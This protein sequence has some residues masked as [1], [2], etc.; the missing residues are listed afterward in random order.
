M[1]KVR[2]GRKS[3]RKRV[4]TQWKGCNRDIIRIMFMN[5]RV[6]TKFIHMKNSYFFTDITCVTICFFICSMFA[7]LI[8]FSLYYSSLRLVTCFYQKYNFFQQFL[9]V[10]QYLFILIVLC[11]YCLFVQQY[12]CVSRIFSFSSIFFLEVSFL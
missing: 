10:Q 5:Y 4:G 2:W 6:K 9:C 8:S 7:L 3:M 1:N 11:Q 12:L